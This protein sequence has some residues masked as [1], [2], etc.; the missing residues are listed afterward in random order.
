MFCHFCHLNDKSEEFAKCF[1]ISIW[2]SEFQYIKEKSR[3]LLAGPANPVP[4]PTCRCF[5]WV[6]HTTPGFAR[7]V[8]LT[9]SYFEKG[10][11]IP[12][13][14]VVVLSS[15]FFKEIAKMAREAIHLCL[16]LLHVSYKSKFDSYGVRNSVLIISHITF[17][18]TTFLEIELNF[19][20][21][22][23]FLLLKALCRIIF[24]I[25]FRVSNHQ[26]LG[27]EN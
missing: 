20:P 18:P 14:I 13:G 11:R 1:K 22:F 25:L 10:C 24:S 6:A 21:S 2:L 5:I 3:G 17:F 12:K 15:L 7:H 16:R 8:F 19:N 23:F 4:Y 26:I 27:K 9:N